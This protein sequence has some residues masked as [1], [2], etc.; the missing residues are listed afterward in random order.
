MSKWNKNFGPL[1]NYELSEFFRDAPAWFSVL[2][3]R[4]MAEG[5]QPFDRLKKQGHN[6]HWVFH[7]YYP[8]VDRFKKREL[9]LTIDSRSFNQE[10]HFRL[11]T[12]P[13]IQ[14]RRILR[15]RV[16][17]NAFK[18]REFIDIHSKFGDGSYE[19]GPFNIKKK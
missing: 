15:L 7:V 1:L 3:K 17:S 8:M 16:K 12:C 2:C 18:L 10:A 19:N 11:K 13:D 4:M 14:V 6:A 5:W 9:I